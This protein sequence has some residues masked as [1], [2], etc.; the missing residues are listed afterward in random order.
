[1]LLY[2]FILKDRIFSK[3]PVKVGLFVHSLVIVLLEYT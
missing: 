1:M 3:V 2:I